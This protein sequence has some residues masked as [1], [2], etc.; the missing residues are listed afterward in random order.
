MSQYYFNL[1]NK[2]FQLRV[3]SKSI[4]SRHVFDI[5]KDIIYAKN[6]PAMNYQLKSS[7]V[8]L[9]KNCLLDAILS[10]LQYFLVY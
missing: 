1:S 4:K 9:N 2:C 7:I 3:F 6:K 8:Q 5:K 10:H